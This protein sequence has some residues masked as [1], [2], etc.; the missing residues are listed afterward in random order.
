MMIKIIFVISMLL[1][2]GFLGACSSDDN[3]SNDFEGQTSIE[4]NE[5]ENSDGNDQM[6]Q[7]TSDEMVEFQLQDENG[8]ECY[9][10][11]EGDNIVFWLTIKND[12][13][14]DAYV[15]RFSDMIG[16]DG[17]RVYSEYGED[18][19]TPWDQ[20]ITTSQALDII[21]AHSFV[22]ILC[23][24]FDIPALY[25]NGKEHYY[26]HMY[27]KKDEKTPLPKGE[28]YSR[29]YIT[30]RDRHNNSK[31]KTITCNRNFVIR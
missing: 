22:E 27:Y 2:T 10:F 14:E 3:M 30:Y 29:F 4:G 5:R 17:F 25:S 11:N 6:I 21:K 12:S 19:G 23:P 31:D 1:T 15:D 7:G 9:D 13:G 18:M 20:I 26:S 24:W 8:K 28:Y 16:W